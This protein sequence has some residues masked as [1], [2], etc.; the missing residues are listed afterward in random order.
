MAITVIT[1]PAKEEYKPGQVWFAR[2]VNR[3]QGRILSLQGQTPRQWFFF[4]KNWIATGTPAGPG[5][6]EDYFV[7]GSSNGHNQ[8]ATAYTAAFTTTHQL[9]MVV[10]HIN[11]TDIDNNRTLGWRLRNQHNYSWVYFTAFAGNNLNFNGNSDENN[12]SWRYIFFVNPGDWRVQLICKDD[13]DPVVN[14]YLWIQLLA[15]VTI[16]PAPNPVFKGTQA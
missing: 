7:M 2:D 10:I 11:A 6:N 1:S 15:G 8:D 14:A 5:N 13:S 16:K 9:N 12:D 4:K 3:I